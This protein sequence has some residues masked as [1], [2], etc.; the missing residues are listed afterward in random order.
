[1]NQVML[2][3]AMQPLANLHKDLYGF[4]FGKPADA[5][6]PLAERSSIDKLHNQKRRSHLA[7]KFDGLDDVRMINVVGGSE[8]PFE[9]AE[10]SL[11]LG[12]MCGDDFN[13]DDLAARAVPGP[14]DR[15]HAALGNF[16]LEVVIADRFQGRGPTG[17]YAPGQVGLRVGPAGERA[18]TT[19]LY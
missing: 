19:F 18:P 12:G 11:I 16:R 3:C 14:I 7:T 13:R 10:Q 1:M 2:V 8:F 5:F 9:A 6:D 17:G 15:P 4:I